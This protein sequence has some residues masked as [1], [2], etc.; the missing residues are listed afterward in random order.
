[1][2]IKR[3]MESETWMSADETRPST[4]FCD[5][6]IEIEG[7]LAK[8]ATPFFRVPPGQSK[9]KIARFGAHSFAH[10]ASSLGRLCVSCK[11]ITCAFN[12]FS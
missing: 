10:L 8:I 4:L 1:M 5:G 7:Q 12:D 2:L 11:Y 6:S 9:L 3:I